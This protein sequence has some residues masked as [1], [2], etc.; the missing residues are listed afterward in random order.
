[1]AR[2]TLL[3]QLLIQIA[4]VQ[5]AA[6]KNTTS[7]SPNNIPNPQIYGAEVLSLTTA[8]ITGYQLDVPSFSNNWP[9]QNITDLDFC[10]VNITITHPGANDSVNNQVWL[11]TTQW[12]GR[13]VGIGGGGYAANMGWDSLGP[14]VGLGYLAAGTDAGVPM[15]SSSADA[16]ALASPGNA[17]QYLLLDFASRSVHEM[18]VMAKQVAESFYGEPP[19]YSYWQG[20]STGGRQGLGEAQL[21]PEDYDGI[22]AAAPAINWNQFTLAQQW[23]YTVM[24]NEGHVPQQC[25][26]D[27]A[28]AAAVSDCDTIDGLLD[29]IIDAP[30]LCSFDPYSL[31]G[32]SFNCDGNSTVVFS[33]ATAKV[34]QL[35]WNG[36]QTVHGV[37]AEQVWQDATT[38]AGNSLWYGLLRG[39]N[40]S[41]LALTSTL[42]NGTT[43]A[44]PFGIS[45]S[46]IRNYLYRNVSF[47]TAGISYP[48][49]ES[50]FR[51][52]I[53]QYD[54]VIG[55]SDANLGPFRAHGGKMISWQGLSDS[56]IMPNGTSNYYDRVSTIYPGTHD[57][58]RLFFAPGV[59]HC[60]SGYGPLP[61]DVLAALAAWV[62]NGTA[63]EI[64]AASSASAINGTVRHQPLCP[65]PAVSK[66]KG[67]DPAVASSYEC[68]NSF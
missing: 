59:G 41:T 23:P 43:A 66:Y 20:C 10:Q 15:N 17:N 47:D 19:Q 34:I 7:C 30:G 39:A 60:G 27:F 48:T 5:A 12:N 1:M 46:W 44:L 28:T 56:T 36:P 63:P 51:L 31:I 65:Y 6:Y 26:F 8:S 18:T 52:S 29:G 61:D 14:A 33:T 11:P 21:Y 2:L 16:W 49:F 58:Y 22:I 35:I 57:F 68:A 42:S 64:L 54:S 38:L 45:D 9:A 13:L 25:E 4:Y 67:G 32:Q 53:Q 55:T 50:L 37:P 40:F 3:Q 24:N 62:E